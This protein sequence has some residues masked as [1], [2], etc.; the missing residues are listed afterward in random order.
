M[1]LTDKDRQRRR[2]QRRRWKVRELKRQL[3]AASDSRVRKRLI[4]KI[5]KLHPWADVPDR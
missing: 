4:T 1:P 3:A 2:R 5:R